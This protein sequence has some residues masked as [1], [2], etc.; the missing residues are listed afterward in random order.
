MSSS[1]SSTGQQSQSICWSNISSDM[2]IWSR[3][4]RMTLRGIRVGL[5]SFSFQHVSHADS[6]LSQSVLVSNL[7]YFSR[8]KAMAGMSQLFAR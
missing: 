1:S 4:A 8:N 6:I 7:L 2:S 3:Y 5:P